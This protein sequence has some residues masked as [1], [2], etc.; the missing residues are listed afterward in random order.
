MSKFKEDSSEREQNRH[1]PGWYALFALI[2]F[3]AIDHLGDL[4]HQL[5]LRR[6]MPW[7]VIL[8]IRNA[9]EVAFSILGVVVAHRQSVKFAVQELG[10]TAPV[11]PALVFAAVASAP[12]LLAFAIGFSINREMTFLSVAVGCFIAP[13]AEEV[14]FRG[15][16]FGQ[17]YRRAKWG[18]W[19]SALVPSVL[20]AAGHAY[21]ST[22]FGELVG[23]LAITS[24]G[25]VLLCW[26]YQRWNYNLWV[27]VAL[28]SAM[29]LWWEVFA[30][31]DTALGGWL[32]NGARFTTVA[33][34]ILL[35][36]FKD[37]FWKVAPAA[38]ESD[39]DMKEQSVK[40]Q[41]DFAVGWVMVN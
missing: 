17:L 22:D 41:G 15:Y 24:V 5:D 23:I 20:F 40:R 2:A 21:Q 8:A 30:V 9:L 6:F 29:N 10:I 35:T 36:I 13:F 38:E 25:S 16:L 19:L 11:R 7:R 39:R 12:M 31:D 26:L 28:H 34:A 4:L 14:L 3:V 18:F 32:A 27:I 37:R 33:I 1:K